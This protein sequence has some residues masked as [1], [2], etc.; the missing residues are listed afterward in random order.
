MSIF[1]EAEAKRDP[2]QGH[3][4]SKAD[5]CT[6][7][8][9]GGVDGNIRF[10]LNNVSTS[11][12]VSNA[13]LARAGRLRQARRH[14]HHQRVRRRL[15][16][17]AW[18]AAPR[19]WPGW[20]RR[21][22]SSCRR[23]TSR[24]TRPRRPSA[25]ATAA[26]TPEYR[27]QVAADSHRAL[28]QGASWSPPASSTTARELPAPSP[29]ARATSATRQTTNVDFTCTVRTEDGRGSGWVARNVA[30]VVELR[31]REATSRPRSSKAKGSAEAK[32]LEPGKYTVILEPAA[33]AGLISLHDVRLRCAPG[34]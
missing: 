23:S 32:A 3:Q 4:L 2:R 13:D 17:D 26:I 1:T 7:T 29:T 12:I 8:L 21:T 16:R 31:C 28:P 19:N 22:P 5:E 24:T 20:R 14:R 11:G 33:A 10:A 18:C 34:R 6:A 25:Q 30:D 15:A 27:A 9:A